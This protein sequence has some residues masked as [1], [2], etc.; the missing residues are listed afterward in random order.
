[1]GRDKN[2]REYEAAFAKAERAKKDGA[3]DE[4]KDSYERALNLLEMSNFDREEPVPEEPYRQYAKML[5]H[6]GDKDSAV[7]V[8]DRFTDY[9]ESR[10][11][12]ST[13]EMEK[14]KNRIIVEDFRQMPGLYT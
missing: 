14:L 8:L 2:F 1:M 4:A 12:K 5:Y 11:R 9:E 6:T 10:G 3:I 13:N 7:E